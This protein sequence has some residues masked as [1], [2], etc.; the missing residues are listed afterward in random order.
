MLAKKGRELHESTC[1]S[2]H[3]EQ[4]RYQ[5][6]HLPRLAGQWQ[7][8]LSLVLEDYWRAEHK[9]PSLFMNIVIT[10]LRSEDIEALAQFYASQR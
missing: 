6:E 5:D 8:Y 10:R 3:K 1:E 7:G 4:G 9:M 2:C